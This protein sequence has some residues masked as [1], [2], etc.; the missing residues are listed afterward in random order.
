MGV[1]NSLGLKELKVNAETKN[2]DG[3]NIDR[4]PNTQEPTGLVQ[5]TAMYPFVRLM[6]EKLAS[7]Q[8]EFLKPHNS[9]TLQMELPLHKME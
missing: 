5:E 7:K 4:F 3:G 6:L 9:I 2:P 8:E 1:A